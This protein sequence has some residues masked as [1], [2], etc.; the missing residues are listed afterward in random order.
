MGGL[1]LRKAIENLFQDPSDL[2]YSGLALV[3]CAI[4]F[5]ST[6]HE[7]TVAADFNDFLTEIL[8]STFG[9]R[10]DE[11]SR[12]LRSFNDSSIQIKRTWERM[13]LMKQDPPLECLTENNQTKFALFKSA[14]VS[15]SYKSR[16]QS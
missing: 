12:E 8:K 3:K 10:K 4:L 15:T 16:N 14:M 13:R 11:I 1:V 9:L 5:L 6:P 7:G 2:K